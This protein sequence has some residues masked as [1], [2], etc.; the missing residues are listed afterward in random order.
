[1]LVCKLSISAYLKKR[2][3]GTLLEL[4]SGEFAGIG[5]TRSVVGGEGRPLR[6]TLGPTA[7]AA[8]EAWTI[9]SAAWSPARKAARSSIQLRVRRRYKS[10]PPAP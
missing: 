8:A 10:V 7:S 5:I 9:E 6:C 1:M 3:Q 2:L 4:K